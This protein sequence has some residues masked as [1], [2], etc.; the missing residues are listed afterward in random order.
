MLVL[1]RKE[2]ERIVIGE[3][4]VLMVTKIVGNTVRLGIEAPDD[5]RIQRGEQA[6]AEKQPPAQ[7]A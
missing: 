6:D 1:T 7:P 4:I 5:V 3:K 2:N